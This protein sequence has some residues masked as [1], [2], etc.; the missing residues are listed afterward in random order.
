LAIKL[1][2]CIHGKLSLFFVHPT[3]CLFQSL[4]FIVELWDCVIPC[5]FYWGVV[6]T[7]IA[8]WVTQIVARQPSIVTSCWLVCTMVDP[9][10]IRSRLFCKNI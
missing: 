7:F 4:Y 10:L 5:H 1:I 2:T 8:M 3:S 6:D 9:K